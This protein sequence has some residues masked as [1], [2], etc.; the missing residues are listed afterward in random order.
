MGLVVMV[1]GVGES[2]EQ[3]GKQRTERSGEIEEQFK[4]HSWQAAV[5]HAYRAEGPQRSK[6]A[7]GSP[8]WT[9]LGCWCCFLNPE[10]Y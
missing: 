2:R 1:V 10:R 9:M 6:V 4:E 7:P 8:F 5:T 3:C